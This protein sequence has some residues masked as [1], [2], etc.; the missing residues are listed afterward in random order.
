M[1][2]LD[3]TLKASRSQ[4]QV[5]E[6]LKDSIAEVEQAGYVVQRP[7]PKDVSAHTLD[8]EHITGKD[9][10]KLA[11]VSCTHLGSK[12][13]QI[14]ALRD[15]CTYAAK[16]AKVDAFVHGGDFGDGPTSRHKNPTEVF[17]HDYGAARDYLVETLPDTGKPWYVISGNHDDWWLIDGGPDMIADVCDK[18]DDMTY[19]GRSLGYLT[20]KN[21]VIEVIHMDSGSAYAYSWK[22]QKHVESLSAER[23]P[24]VC[25]LGNFH[26]FCALMY[27]GVLGIQLPSFQRQTGWMAGKSLVSEVGG[28]IVEIGLQPKGIAP[29]TKFETV[30]FAEPIDEDWP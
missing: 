9:R 22:M 29:L 25:L 27:R 7:L 26:K 21:T 18:R 24:D 23:K 4:K 10:L 20:F 30:Y 8:L 6:D 1:P 15:F 2:D 3:D 28:V 12:Y 5:R 14:T 11:V 17:K 19:L 16:V 13:Q